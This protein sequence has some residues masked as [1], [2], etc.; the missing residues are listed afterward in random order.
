MRWTVHAHQRCTQ[1]DIDIE[2]LL[3]QRGSVVPQAL[4]G[5]TYRLL[6]ADGITAVIHGDLEGNPIVISAWH[7]PSKKQ[8]AKVL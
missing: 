7:T 1:R 5:T 3:L 2:A 4:R 6:T 8:V